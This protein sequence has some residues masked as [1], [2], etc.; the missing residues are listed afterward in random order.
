MIKEE[1][2]QENHNQINS[3]T[4]TKELKIIANGNANIKGEKVLITEKLFDELESINDTPRCGNTSLLNNKKIRNYSKDALE[5]YR[6]PL[7]CNPVI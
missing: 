6:N 3:I 2:K 7:N 5:T 4:T 1:M